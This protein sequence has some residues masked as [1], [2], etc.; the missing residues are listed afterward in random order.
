MWYYGCWG[1]S[2]Y[3]VSET[4]LEQL[5]IQFAKDQVP[6]LALDC[7]KGSLMSIDVSKHVLTSC[8]LDALFRLLTAYMYDLPCCSCLYLERHKYTQDSKYQTFA[9]TAR[10]RK[11]QRRLQ[12]RC[13][14]RWKKRRWENGGK[15]LDMVGRTY[16]KHGKLWPLVENS[17]LFQDKPHE[18]TSSLWIMYQSV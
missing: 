12:H 11:D 4:T 15:T 10:S 3:S 13:R 1:I 14:A 5:F 9:C 18:L 8:T 16:G 6:C 17:G 7:K 2:E